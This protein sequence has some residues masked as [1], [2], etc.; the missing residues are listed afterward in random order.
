MHAREHRW[1][2]GNADGIKGTPQLY[3]QTSVGRST[4]T[5]QLQSQLALAFGRSHITVSC[6]RSRTGWTGVSLTL[7]AGSRAQTPRPL[8]VSRQSS[9]VTHVA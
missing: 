3:F 5:T 6:L 8:T 1:Y 2:K 9:G 7:P 4:K